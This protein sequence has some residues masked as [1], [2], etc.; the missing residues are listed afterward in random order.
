M[1]AEIISTGCSRATFVTWQH[2]DESDTKNS[3]QNAKKYVSRLTNIWAIY[4]PA[5]HPKQEE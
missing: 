4:A 3:S 2:G 1:V 5:D